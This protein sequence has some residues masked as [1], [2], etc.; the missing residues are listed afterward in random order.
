MARDRSFACPC[1]EWD[2]EGEAVEWFR[3]GDLEREGISAAT[4]RKHIPQSNLLSVVHGR[5]EGEKRDRKG[6]RRGRAS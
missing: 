3:G 1:A 2:Q 4:V 5:V 6:G